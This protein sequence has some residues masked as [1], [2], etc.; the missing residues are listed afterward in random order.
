MKAL[1]KAGLAIKS[2]RE[3]MGIFLATLKTGDDYRKPTAE[4]NA[5]LQAFNATLADLQSEYNGIK[6]IADADLMNDA[7]IKAMRERMPTN[8]PRPDE[9]GEDFRNRN[10]RLAGLKCFK[11]AGK[12]TAEEQAYDFGQFLLATAFQRPDA[13]AHCRKRGI[14][15]F[16]YVSDASGEIKAMSEGTNSAG[17]ALV[18]EE[19][20]TNIIDL[21]EKYGIL[22]N[23]LRVEPMSSETRRI[24]RRASGMTVYYPGEGVALTASDL[25]FNSVL[26]TAKKYAALGIYSSELGEDAIIDFGDRIAEEAAYAFSAAED[27]NGFNGDGTSA[28]CSTVGILPKIKGLSSTIAY[29][30]G[31]TVGSGNLWSELVLNDYLNVVGNLPV[32]A[33]TP[34]AAWYCHK[35]HYYS[36]MLKLALA[37]GGVTETE[38]I[39]GQRTP[40]FLGYPVKFVQKMA[41]SEANSQVCA[42]LGDLNLGVTM[43]DRRLI[44]VAQS[45]QYKFDTDQLAVKVTQRIDINV[46]DAGNAD[47]TAASRVAGPYVGLITAAS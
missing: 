24:P 1:E 31:L 42:I 14:K 27:D 47:A 21:R 23:S 28:Y 25:A 17:G 7:E 16:N 44:T 5:K 22:R 36:T 45:D 12:N 10:L 46:H 2:K 40:M 4:E 39:N 26:L 34:N 9:D 35:M 3:E 11:S 6:S 32:Y 43:G 19:F 13:L 30:A 18:P 41:R 15:S 38:V 8:V 29:I 37:S 33:D 20:A